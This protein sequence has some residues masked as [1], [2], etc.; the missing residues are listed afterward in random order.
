[1]RH[2]TTF[3]LFLHF[4]CS[5]IQR[6]PLFCICLNFHI[7]FFFQIMAAWEKNWIT[8]RNMSQH[9]LTKIWRA[10]C[11]VRNTW[12][13]F[14]YL[15]SAAVKRK[16]SGKKKKRKKEQSK[17]K[18]LHVNIIV[19]IVYTVWFLICKRLRWMPNYKSATE[20][21]VK[22]QSSVAQ[23]SILKN[24]FPLLNHLEAA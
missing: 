19:Y 5:F 23:E 10:Y 8:K 11:D 17:I 24:D 4:L 6:V 15:W 12:S 3:N 21:Q 13:K 7:F 22:K 2:E 9:N 20:M 14:R 1:M 18:E 16:F